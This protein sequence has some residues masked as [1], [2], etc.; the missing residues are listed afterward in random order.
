VRRAHRRPRSAA[1][2]DQPQSPAARPGSIGKSGTGPGSRPQSSTG[3]GRGRQPRA[4]A[5]TTQAGA[6]TTRPPASQSAA[7]A[8]HPERADELTISELVGPHGL[9][10]VVKGMVLTDFPEDL[11][12]LEEVILEGRVRTVA[13][14]L[15]VQ[16]H[17]SALFFKFEGIDTREAAEA[18][19]GV[20]VKIPRSAAHELPPDH[21]Y[22]SDIVGMEVFTEDGRSLG[23]IREIRR[24]GSND[25]YY[26]ERALIPALREA[27]TTLDVPNRRMVVQS[28]LVVED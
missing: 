24:T 27:V 13:R 6:S 2:P 4:G 18:L 21:Y 15:S 11:E 19:R 3:G 7:R 5:S 22:H 12:R 14:V 20:W 8:P 28:A 9:Q 25:V 17:G 16:L 23:T 10:G 26:T 1:G